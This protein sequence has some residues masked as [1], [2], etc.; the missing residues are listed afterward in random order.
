MERFSAFL[1][2]SY[3]QNFISVLYCHW[4]ELPVIRFLLSR[5]TGVFLHQT[6]IDI[7]GQ[8]HSCPDGNGIQL[9][10]E[11]ETFSPKQADARFFSARMPTLFCYQY[12]CFG[13]GVAL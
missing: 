5:K 2:V 10:Y 9:N 8:L 7:S 3:C 6:Y 4:Y 12:P 11:T 13:D 1:A